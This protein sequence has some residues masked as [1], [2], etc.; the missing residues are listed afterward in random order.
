MSSIDLFLLGFLNK[1][2]I[3]AYDLAKFIE[4]NQ[5]NQMIKISTPAVYKNLIRLKEKRYLSSKK[6]QSGNSSQKVIYSITNKGEKYFHSLMVKQSKKDFL[7]YFDFNSFIVNLDQVD[8]KKMN[9][10]LDNFQEVLLKKK[11][12]YSGYKNKF[13][14]APY[15]AKSIINQLYDVNDL[16]L[17]WLDVYKK[18]KK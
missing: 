16:I 1:K 11:N 18:N 17:K 12:L 4:E 9:E 6:V 14:S 3:S 5:L 15:A 10:L 7:I 2:S 8:E 13:N